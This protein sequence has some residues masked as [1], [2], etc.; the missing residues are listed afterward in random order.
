MHA[1]ADKNEAQ[2]ITY[3][4]QDALHVINMFVYAPLSDV[5]SLIV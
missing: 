1:K 3:E 5:N 4:T 2:Y